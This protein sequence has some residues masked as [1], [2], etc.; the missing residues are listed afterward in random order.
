MSYLLNKLVKHGVFPP[1][2]IKNPPTLG[3]RFAL[4]FRF[5]LERPMDLKWLVYGYTITDVIV[6]KNPILV[7]K[8][9]T[10]H[11]APLKTSNFKFWINVGDVV[12]EVTLWKAF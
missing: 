2:G 7:K 6:L 11:G 1:L 9:F 10:P 8:S 12:E 4:S 5:V 3:L